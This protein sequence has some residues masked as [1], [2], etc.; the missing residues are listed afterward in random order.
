M[1]L[2]QEIFAGQPEWVDFAAIDKS[3]DVL[4]FENDPHASQDAYGWIVTPFSNKCVV[5][6]DSEAYKSNQWQRSIVKRR[7][8]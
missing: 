3:G 4:G 8:V 5:I 6:D 7:S 2:T 1:T